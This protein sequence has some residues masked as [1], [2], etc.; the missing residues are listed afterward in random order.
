MI[1]KYYSE[2]D[3]V[4]AAKQRIINIFSTAPKVAVSIS[5]GKDS[6]VL[7][8]LVYKL[9]V[10]GQIDKSKLVI[11]FIDEEAIFPC[12]EKIVKH[13]RLQ[14]L[15][16]GVP[17]R[18]WC[19]EVKHFNCFNMLTND[20]SFICWDRYKKDVWVREMP[21]FALTDHPLLN[22]RVDSYQK[23]LPRLNKDAIQ[24]SGVRCSESM[25]RLASLA[26]KKNM[27]MLYP[28]YD[29]TDKDVWR[30]IYENNLE[31]P[32]AYLYLYQTGTPINRLRLS[33]FFSIDTAAT[34][35]S[36]CEYYPNLFDKICKREPNAYI[37]MLYYDTEMFRRQKKNKQTEDDDE[38][39]YKA[40]V[41]ELLYNDE[42][43]VSRTAKETQKRWQR[44]LALYGT[45][46]TNEQ[47]KK[48]YGSLIGGDPKGRAY[49]SIYSSIFQNMS[50]GAKNG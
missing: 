16:I 21:S 19:I 46:M 15:Q 50:K 11:D 39:S 31:I 47:Y 3:V 42:Y 35:V 29:M 40:K 37:A 2:I 4:S 34:L 23:F 13:I 26:N 14:W 5:G 10:S 32:D 22:K 8:D 9:C 38:I 24:L 36:M 18:W 33:Q 12:V 27:Q 49:R 6:I 25:Q 17:F 28:I 7:N 41:L 30:Y 45:I 43:F 48:V 1:K 44:A 20:E